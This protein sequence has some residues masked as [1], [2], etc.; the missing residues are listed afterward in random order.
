MNK[1]ELAKL[2]DGREYGEEISKSEE[3]IAKDAGLVVVYGASDDLCEFAGAIY[4]EVG[5]YNS[6]EVWLNKK[7]IISVDED[8]VEVLEKHDCLDFVMKD[9]KQIK[10]NKGDGYTFTYETK[11]PHATFDIKDDDEPYCRGIIFSIDSL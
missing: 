1:E 4:D 11:I 6:G 9:A 3:K 10:I 5:C 7:G 8:E 2:L